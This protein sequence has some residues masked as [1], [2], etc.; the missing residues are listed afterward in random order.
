VYNKKV[1]AICSNDYK[2]PNVNETQLI[3]RV[4]KLKKKANQY[5]PFQDCIMD[6]F[7]SDHEHWNDLVIE[8]NSFGKWANGGAGKFNWFSD[9]VE[10]HSST[11]ISVELNY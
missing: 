1:T 5:L 11:T 6:V 2:C 4:L 10:L 8:F 3:Q 7:V 9:H